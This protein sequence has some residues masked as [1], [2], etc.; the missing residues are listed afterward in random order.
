MKKVAI[1]IPARYQSVRFPGKPLV[2]LS[3]SSGKIAPLIY[4]VWNQAKRVI[5][6]RNDYSV[7]LYIATDDERIREC[8]SNFGASVVMTDISCLN[9]TERCLDA[10]LKDT[11]I[12]ADIIINFQGDAPLT[13]VSF[14]YAIINHMLDNADSSVV[15]PCV[16]MSQEQKTQ[17]ISDMKQGISGGTTVVFN[18]YKQALYF[19]K[20]LIPFLPNDA[21]TNDLYNIFLHIGL[22][23]YSTDALHQYGNYKPGALETSE[24][25]EQL[26]F[27][28]ND[29]S[30]SVLEMP[31]PPFSLWEL[32][33]P[34]DKIL[35]ESVLKTYT[36]F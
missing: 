36:S 1:I 30:I 5:P 11:R 35:I 22:Y 27:L 12:N 4:W 28:E 17:F 14:V 34:S 18:K 20:G 3:D 15:T 16:R 2:Q 7:T 8:A 24:K 33:H 31:S 21:E 10:I 29:I 32:N 26:R 25:L 9:G 19:S 13:P 23:A 6:L